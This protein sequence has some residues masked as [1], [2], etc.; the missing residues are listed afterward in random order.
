[1]IK[2]ENQKNEAL[3]KKR[4]IGIKKKKRERESLSIQY[5]FL[6]NKK[7]MKTQTLRGT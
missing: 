1:M 2:K 7:I 3:G 6:I 4:F 5:Q